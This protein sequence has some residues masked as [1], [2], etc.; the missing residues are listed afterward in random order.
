MRRSYSIS[1]EG[2]ER[3]LTNKREVKEVVNENGYGV[4]KARVATAD[5]P[6]GTAYR[7]L[8]IYGVGQG[9]LVSYVP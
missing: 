7:F 6:L 1:Y 2:A 4:V 5:R 8:G 9:R 3:K